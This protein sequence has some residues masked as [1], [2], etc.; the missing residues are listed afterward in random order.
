MLAFQQIKFHPIWTSFG[1]SNQQL[2][3]RCPNC[4]AGPDYARFWL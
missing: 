4:P 2:N 1:R 3:P